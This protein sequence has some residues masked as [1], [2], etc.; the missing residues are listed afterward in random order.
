[1]AWFNSTAHLLLQSSSLHTEPALKPSLHLIYAP[2]QGKNS[3]YSCKTMNYFQLK[4][5]SLFYFKAGY[6]RK[7]PSI[8]SKLITNW[9]QYWTISTDF[10]VYISQLDYTIFLLVYSTITFE[11]L[12]RCSTQL[13]F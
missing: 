5:S 9:A 2:A 11:T 4:T 8:T 1:M 3:T 6:S 12:L 7:S 10:R 13:K